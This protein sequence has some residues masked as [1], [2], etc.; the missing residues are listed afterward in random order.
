MG[1][2]SCIMM[3]LHFTT[4]N[5]GIRTET[6]EFRTLEA[7]TDTQSH[8]CSELGA[9]VWVTMNSLRGIM[10]FKLSSINL[11]QP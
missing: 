9:A 3:I 1:A 6:N 11:K 8:A 5:H 7:F 4:A 10:G 2:H